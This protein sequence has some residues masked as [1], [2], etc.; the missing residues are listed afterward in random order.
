M[1]SPP[2]NLPR[3]TTDSD[4]PQRTEAEQEA[5]SGRVARILVLDGEPATRALGARALGEEGYEVVTV[6]AGHLELSAATAGDFDV[7]A[8]TTACPA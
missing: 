3:R 2:L 5:R 4:R 6:A 7:A 1:I 8:T